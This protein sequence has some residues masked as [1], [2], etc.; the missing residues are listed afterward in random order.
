MVWELAFLHNWRVVE[1]STTGQRLNRSETF[2]PSQKTRAMI[3]MKLLNFLLK[4]PPIIGKT[5]GSKSAD[6]DLEETK[7]TR[8]LFDRSS[9]IVAT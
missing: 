1:A 7:L 6:L 9:P 2:L 3:S 8:T 4:Y 5:V